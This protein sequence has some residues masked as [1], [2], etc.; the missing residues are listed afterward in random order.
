MKLITLIL[1]IALIQSTAQAW[2]TPV[3]VGNN[4]LCAETHSHDGSGLGVDKKSAIRAAIAN[5]ESFTNFEYGGAWAN[6][7]ISHKKRKPW[8]RG[9]NGMIRCNV[10]SN[11]CR[12]K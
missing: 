5:W 7:K 9:D 3:P 8:C 10:Q 2:W 11:P 4:K 1:G 6:Y 12:L